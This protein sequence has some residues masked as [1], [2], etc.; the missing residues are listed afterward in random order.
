M[1]LGGGYIGWEMVDVWGTAERYD[2]ISLY[3][4]FSGV[5][6]NI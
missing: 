1:Q 2:D 6:K 3:I 5:K 4:K